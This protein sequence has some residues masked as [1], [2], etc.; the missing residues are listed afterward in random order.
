MK[1]VIITGG[2]G[3]IGSLV[4]KDCLDRPDVG[5]VTSIV[6]RA[7]G[8][9][10]AKLREVVL[11][12]MGDLAPI[13]DALTDQ[14]IAFY[15]LGVYTGALPKDEFRR[16][17]VDFTVTFT[18]ALKQG[19]PGAVLCFLSGEGADRTEKARMQFARDKGAAENF[20][21]QAGL[22]RVHSFRPG[23]IYP[24]HPRDEPNAAY[25]LMRAL[26]KPLL[27]KLMAASSIPSTELA[28]AMVQVGFEGHP[29]EVL[30]NR[31]IRRLRR[32]DRR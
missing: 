8:M 14:D 23:Y 26:Y 3:M 30:E 32:L 4:L 27:S 20:L 15:C 25:R 31:D 6:R 13:T 28:A 17:T 5:Q 18:R 12:D 1:N 2:T 10:H 11:G 19:S 16:V 29:L 21:F 7:S 22:P 24:V 9:A